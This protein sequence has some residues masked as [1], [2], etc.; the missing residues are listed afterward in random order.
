MA[1]ALVGNRLGMSR[2]GLVGVI[3]SNSAQYA[4]LVPKATGIQN[5]LVN[6]LKSP[7]KAT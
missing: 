4:S 7:R 2:S 5:N 6:G 1:T 3:V